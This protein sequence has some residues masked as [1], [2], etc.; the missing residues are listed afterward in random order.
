MHYAKFDENVV[1]LNYYGMF[2]LF[3]FELD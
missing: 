1:K 2:V 3:I